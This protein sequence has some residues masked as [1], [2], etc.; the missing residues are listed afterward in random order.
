MYKAVFFDFDDTLVRTM[1]FQFQS[2]RQALKMAADFEL[3]KEVFNSY[4]GFNGKEILK[5]LLKD[6]FAAEAVYNVKHVLHR[7]R[8]DKVQPIRNVVKLLEMFTG[9]YTTALISSTLN[10]EGVEEAIATLNISFDYI[11]TGREYVGKLKPDPGMY[12][13][14][15]KDLN[16]KPEECVGFED[17]APGL[18]ALKTAG[19][20]AIDVRNFYN[21]GR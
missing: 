19:I 17:S 20:F 6:E 11:L 5:A 18:L 9:K 21:E 14:A 13:K 15:M 2:Y 16:V 3:T 4:A 7:M 8:K 12:L 1:D 10:R